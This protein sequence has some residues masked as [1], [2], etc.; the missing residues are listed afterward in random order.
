MQHIKFHLKRIV[1]LIPLRV[2]VMDVLDCI[3]NTPLVKLKRIPKKGRVF[4]KL[5]CAN[6]GG[7]IKDRAALFG[8]RHMLKTGIINKDTILIESSSGNTGIGL[9]LVA[10]A[11]GMKMIV[12]MPESMSEERK[13]LIAAYGA[14]LILTPA[15]EGVLGAYKQAEKLEKELPNA[16]I[17]GQFTNKAMHLAHSRGT[18]PEIIH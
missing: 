4:V 3:G 9:S 7:S 16:K 10:A 5:E 12:T 15:A 8:I 6:V 17:V 2:S 11:L 18:A 14:Q 1:K 13:K